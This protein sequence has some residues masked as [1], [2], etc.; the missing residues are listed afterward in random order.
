MLS[1]RDSFR[2]AARTPGGSLNKHPARWEHLQS[3]RLWKPGTLG[4]RA[5]RVSCPSLSLSVSCPAS[6]WLVHTWG[7]I[8][9]RVQAQCPARPH[10]VAS[11]LIPQVSGVQP[12]GCGCAS[13]ERR[14]PGVRAGG[15][16]GAWGSV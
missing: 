8:C 6:R 7:I 5:E 10:A 3:A 1:P 11:P 4:R 15:N 2:A 16:E 12:V 13:D 9:P 14:G